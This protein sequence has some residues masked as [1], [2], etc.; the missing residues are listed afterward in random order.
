MSGTDRDDRARA[1]HEAA[2]AII[3]SRGAGALTLR[4]LAD[5]LGGSMTLVTH[6]FPTQAHLMRGVLKHERTLLDDDLACAAATD[7]PHRQLYAT[8]ECLMPLTPSRLQRARARVLLAL[9]ASGSEPWMREHVTTVEARI[10]AAILDGLRPLVPA[11]ELDQ[12]ADVVRV[13]LNGIVLSTI[14]HPAPWTPDRQRAVL[15]AMLRALIAEV[16]RAQSA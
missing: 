14:E 3:A 10:R 8:L 4:E 13:V 12:A 5:A 6:Y 9:Q 1:V 7:D 2:T 15:D 11:A 16:G